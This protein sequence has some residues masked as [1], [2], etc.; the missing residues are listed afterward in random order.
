MAIYY[1]NVFDPKAIHL[2]AYGKPLAVIRL[3]AKKVALVVDDTMAVINT[4]DLINVLQTMIE[5]G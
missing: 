3:D 2:N 1:V 5:E 4:R